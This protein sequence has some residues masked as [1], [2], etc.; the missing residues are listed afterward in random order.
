VKTAHLPYA[1]SSP[2]MMQSLCLL[3]QFAC[4]STL[5]GTLMSD[6]TT[7]CVQLDSNSSGNLEY[8]GNRSFLQLYMYSMLH[9]NTHLTMQ[10]NLVQT[11]NCI[12]PA[13]PV[14]IA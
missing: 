4:D 7:V 11:R 10:M 12:K 14:H 5:E 2:A 6:E 1:S 3:Q 13:T 8:S 9:A